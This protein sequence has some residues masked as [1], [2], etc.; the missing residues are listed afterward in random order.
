MTLNQI[1][2]SKHAKSTTNLVIDWVNDDTDRFDELMKLVLG[3]DTLLSQRAAWPMSYIVINH[4]HLIKPYLKSLV[5][6]A[7]KE[8]HP[9][10]KRNTFRFLKEIEIPKTNIPKIIDAALM[11]VNNPKEP[12]A[13]VCFAFYTLLKIARQFPEIKNEI[14]FATELHLEN[15]ASG[16]QNAIQKVRKE[17]NRLN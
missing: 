11:V 12:I 2:L 6:L 7:K 13:V 8:V 9:A 1:L 17:L 10:I 4:P 14:L 3:K 15:K 5:E 16:L